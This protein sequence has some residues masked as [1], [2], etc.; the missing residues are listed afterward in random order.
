MI[1]P[2]NSDSL[3][4]T[5]RVDKPV[6]H[7]ISTGTGLN[8]IHNL[9]KLGYHQDTKVTFIDISYAVLSFMKALVEEWDGVDYATFY[10]NQVKFVPESYDYDLV[11]HESRI[12]ELQEDGYGNGSDC[13][14]RPNQRPPRQVW[15]RSRGHA[16]YPL[17]VSSP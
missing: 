14:N 1:T 7:Y 13:I 5:L 9:I 16:V 17:A 4:N 2:W 3:P 6:D 11:N 12:R 10:M 15:D 8:W